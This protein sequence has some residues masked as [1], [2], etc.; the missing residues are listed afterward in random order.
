MI[1]HTK[2]AQQARPRAACHHALVTSLR[3]LAVL[4]GLLALNVLASGSLMA[5]SL[6]S[7]WV[8]GHF[9]RTRLV[10]GH[11]PF[12]KP[13]SKQTTTSP[14]AGLEM[15]LAP[16][17]KTYWRV[18]GDAGGVPPE[19]DFSE[20]ENVASAVVYYPAPRRLTDRAGSTIGYKDRVVFPVVIEAK[21]AKL[22]VKLQLMLVFGV[23]HDI[24]VPSEATYEITIPPGGV[25]LSTDIMSALVH[26]PTPATQTSRDSENGLPR[27]TKIETDLTTAEPTITLHVSFPGGTEGADVFVEGPVGEYVPM[28]VHKGKGAD[29]T[30][31]YVI[32]L[33]KGA[34]VAALKGKSLRVTMVS[35]AQ[36]AETSF[37]LQ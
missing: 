36:Q 5:Q 26:V 18:P 2:A 10:A 25:P 27:L 4:A 34:D 7:E 30:Q 15:D 23:C 11:I 22:P 29:G 1:I 28:T 6:A 31:I 20:S 16:G 14:A 21:D 19:F 33:S 3:T 32:E 12:N 9:V 35:D 17:W 24:C 13:G 37:I 8:Q